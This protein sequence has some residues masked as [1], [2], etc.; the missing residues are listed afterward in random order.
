MV[1]VLISF[2]NNDFVCPIWPITN[3]R[4]GGL[5]NIATIEGIET[6][7][8]KVCTETIVIRVAS[9]YYFFPIVRARLISP[10]RCSVRY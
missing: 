1:Q 2:E 10:Q 5:A 9:S 6:I 4:L 8:W 7:K 3:H